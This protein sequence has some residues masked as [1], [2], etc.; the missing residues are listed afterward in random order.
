MGG[1]SVLH[2]VG[3]NHG[4]V[5]RLPERLSRHLHHGPHHNHVIVGVATDAAVTCRHVLHYAFW[6]ARA[7]RGAF[8][9]AE[10]FH[11][12]PLS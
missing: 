8:A 6:R 2:Y 10:R 7:A 9:S 11:E 1:T 12:A 4:T 3:N 5:T